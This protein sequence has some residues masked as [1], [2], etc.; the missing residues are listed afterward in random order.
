MSGNR[1]VTAQNLLEPADARIDAF[2]SEGLSRRVEQ[3]WEAHLA[4]PVDEMIG[5]GVSTRNE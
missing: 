4:A 5:N 2:L 3:S 1:Q